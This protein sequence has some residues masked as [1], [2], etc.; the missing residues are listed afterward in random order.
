VSF[1]W[2]F[3][4]L[5]ISPKKAV[6][7]KPSLKQSFVSQESGKVDFCGEGVVKRGL[8]HEARAYGLF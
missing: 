3:H 6:T 7:M 4:Q 8:V 2:Y 1:L 5:F